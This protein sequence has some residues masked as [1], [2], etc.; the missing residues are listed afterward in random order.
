MKIKT[1]FSDWR[2][3][4]VETATAYVKHLMSHITTMSDTEKEKY[5]NLKYLAGATVAQL[6]NRELQEV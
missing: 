5:I 4:D 1:H 3:V 6:L 2:E